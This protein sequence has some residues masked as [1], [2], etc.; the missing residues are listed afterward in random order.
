VPQ[1]LIRTVWT[2][3]ARTPQTAVVQLCSSFLFHATAMRAGATGTP[4]VALRGLTGVAASPANVLRAVEAAVGAQV[5]RRAEA[6]RFEEFV[7]RGMGFDHAACQAWEQAHQPLWCA[8]PRPE[9]SR[10]LSRDERDRQAQNSY[11][12]VREFAKV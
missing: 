12:S 11:N 10:W 1:P 2:G 4:P 3:L 9:F 8:P 5:L 6:S 7:L